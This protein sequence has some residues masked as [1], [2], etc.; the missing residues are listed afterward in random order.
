MHDDIERFLVKLGFRVDREYKICRLVMPREDLTWQIWN[1][2]L[3]LY[4]TG[5]DGVSLAV[6]YD[7]SRIKLRSIAKLLQAD[8]KFGFAITWGKREENTIERFSRI[9]NLITLVSTVPIPRKTIWVG[10]A[11]TRE[12][13]DIKF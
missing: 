7:T 10:I 11:K 12:W 3:D 5:A 8:V 2:L 1:G 9:K 4:A 13:F 6:E